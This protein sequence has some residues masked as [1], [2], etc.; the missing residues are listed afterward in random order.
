MASR[1][2]AIANYRGPSVI[3][4]YKGVPGILALTLEGG[5]RGSGYVCGT[6]KAEGRIGSGFQGAFAAGQDGAIT[7][8]GVRASGIQYFEDAAVAAYYGPGCAAD[9]SGCGD[10]AM[11]GSITSIR[12][13][14]ASL[15]DSCNPSG[16]SITLVGGGT[17]FQATYE[18]SGSTIN[19][20]FFADAASHGSGYEHPLPRIDVSGGCKCN[21]TD[22]WSPCL[23]VQVASGAIFL[24]H[25]QR[26]VAATISS[27]RAISG[28]RWYANGILRAA[29]AGG[30]GLR[31]NFTVDAV[32]GAVRDAVVIEGGHSYLPDLELRPYY[33]LGCANDDTGCSDKVMDGTV[34]MIQ[35]LDPQGLVCSS[36]GN[37][38]V[39]YKGHPEVA[40]AHFEKLRLG[41]MGRFYFKKAADHGSGFPFGVDLN[42][43]VQGCTCRGST[44]SFGACLRVRAASGA[45]LGTSPQSEIARWLCAGGRHGC[46]GMLGG[47]AGWDKGV[48]FDATR[49]TMLDT[50][51]A[52]AMEPFEING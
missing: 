43:S 8:V 10:W 41:G 4:S 36:D 15:I 16:G 23:E 31:A 48:P 51:K 14:N 25:P 26:S 38:T 3:Y 49:P 19:R 29:S 44:S 32:T 2:V 18:S 35:R 6:L 34:A 37:V 11:E 46:V 52:V 17:G 20:V 12:L 27:A 47:G 45:A 30:A 22:D 9:D 24:P 5:I 50:D 21:A 1:H 40:I 42:I 33:A 13:V 39:S 7:H 28:G